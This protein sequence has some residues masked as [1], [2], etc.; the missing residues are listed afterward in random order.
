MES[1]R[2]ISLPGNE[3]QPQILLLQTW[4]LT[5]A[6]SRLLGRLRSPQAECHCGDIHGDSPLHGILDECL[7]ARE[8]SHLFPVFVPEILAALETGNRGDDQSKWGRT[9]SIFFSS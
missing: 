1:R 8:I 2:Q 6:C 4:A 7:I 9:N 5:T 3:F